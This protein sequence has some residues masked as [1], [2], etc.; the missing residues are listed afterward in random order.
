MGSR[1]RCATVLAKNIAPNA[2][3]CCMAVRTLYS[4]NANWL[5]T[6]ESKNRFRRTV[7]KN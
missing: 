1:V 6:S 7:S 5:L 2:F 3:S 4:A